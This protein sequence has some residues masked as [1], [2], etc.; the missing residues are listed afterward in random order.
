MDRLAD[1][2]NNRIQIF[3]LAFVTGDHNT[4]NLFLLLAKFIYIAIH[5]KVTHVA[6]L[7]AELGYS[8]SLS[9]NF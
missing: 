7:E 9:N 5:Y 1:K 8:L 3:L 2:V 6:L 4:L